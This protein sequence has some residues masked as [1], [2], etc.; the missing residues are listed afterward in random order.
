MESTN[1]NQFLSMQISEDLRNSGGQ[2]EFL[3]ALQCRC[4]S[5]IQ[6]RG[7]GEEGERR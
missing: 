5:G 7:G 4:L 1:G 6:K 3:V 2:G